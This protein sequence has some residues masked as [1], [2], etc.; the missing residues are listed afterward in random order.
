MSVL[1]NH[2]VEEVLGDE[3][4]VNGVRLA[5]STGGAQPRSCGHRRVHRHRP[6]AQHRPVRRAARHARAATSWCTSGI[7]GDATATS[8]PGVFAAGDVADH[9]YRQAITSAGSGCMAALD[10]DRY[11]E[12]LDTHTEPSRPAR[13]TCQGPVE[14]HCS[15][16]HVTPEHWNALGA[17]DNPFSAPRVPGRARAHAAASARRTGWEPRYLTL[18]DGARTRRGRAGLPEDALLRRV[19]VRLRLGRGLRA[20]RPPLLP[21]AH[22]GRS[23]HARHRSAAAGAPGPGPRGAAPPAAHGPRAATR[24]PQRLS[25]AHALFLDEAARAACARRGWLLRRDCQ[26]HWHNR[27]YATSR[28]TWRRFTAEK[29][30]KARRERRRV[31]GGRH[32]FRDA[33]RCASSMSRCSITST[34]CTATPS[35]ATGTSRT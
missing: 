13:R 21:E 4:G 35:C 2:T 22:P 20:R 16:E 8:V 3:Q 31:A 11:L 24:Q 1:W 34:S 9:V 10:A 26:F 30:K 15:I 6:H 18:H 5:R 23:L 27:G 25:G 17:A 28:S 32:A 33:L 19:R 29:R 12:P 7:E 14:F